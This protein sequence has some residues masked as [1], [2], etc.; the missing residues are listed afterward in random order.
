MAEKKTLRVLVVDDQSAV[1]EVVA[2]T[3]R[4]A[5][6]DVVGTASDGAQAVERAAALQPDLV[7]MD[8]VMPRMNGVEAMEAILRAGSARWVVIMSGEYRSMGFTLAEIKK[9]GARDFLEKPFDVTRLF[10]LLDQ[11]AAE[12]V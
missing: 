5:G 12:K 4:Y 2:D 7:V 10:T 9:R 6:H 1:A 3:I 11:I 8:V